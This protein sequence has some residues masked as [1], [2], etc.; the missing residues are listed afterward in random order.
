MKTKVDQLF[1]KIY[2]DTTQYID[3]NFIDGDRNV[4]RLNFAKKITLSKEIVSRSFRQII[5]KDSKKNTSDFINC[6]NSV[7]KYLPFCSS[8]KAFKT[9]WELRTKT[10]S[11][12]DTEEIVKLGGQFI[13]ENDN[14][15]IFRIEM[16]GNLYH[17]KRFM[18][19][20]RHSEG[21]YDDKLDDLG[22][23]TYE[24]P[25]NLSGML[26]YR[27]SEM[28]TLN[29]NIPYLVL[30][31]IWFE[32]DIEGSLNQ[33]F[34]ICPAKVKLNS[35]FDLNKNISNPIHLQLIERN[36]AYSIINRFESLND[37]DLNLSVRDQLPENLA[38]EYSYD[39]ICNSKKGKKIKDWAKQ[40]GKKCVDGT[41]CNNVDFKD[42]R[43]SDIAFGHIISQNWSKSFSY[44]LSKVNHP[45]NLYLTCKKCNSSLN[46]NFPNNVL[47]GKIYSEGTI[48]DWLRNNKAAIE[49][50]NKS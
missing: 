3:S 1:Q 33:I 43:N 8:P 31:I 36:E 15:R 44:L 6:I 30:V 21:N 13:P 18:K 22:N 20:V 37:S 25:E 49:S 45:D 41:I 4:G 17:N 39:K 28:I 46:D 11:I 27:L 7:R 47:K 16:Q 50:V 14:S 10:I 35:K 40:N 2:N 19:A 38:R 9:A 29:F 5:N 26:R 23:F 12:N 34:T 48:G 32:Y 24:P 42:L